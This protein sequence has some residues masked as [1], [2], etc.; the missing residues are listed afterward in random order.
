M[1]FERA[2]AKGLAVR[3]FG[4][5]SPHALTLLRAAWPKAVGE[6][7]GRRTEVVALEGVTLR[8]RVPDAGWR[9]VLHRMQ[10]EIL[11]RLREV[12]GPLAPRRL[13]F[14]EGRIAVADAAPAPPEPVSSDERCPPGLVDEAAAIAD[15]EVRARFVETA[16]R[17]LS[18]AGA[19]AGR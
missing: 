18:R 13:G 7:L 14:V 17:Y 12:A 6:D 5:D 3:L 19:R 8:I 15:P 9:R 1:R 16:G 10:G 11:A 4:K 2:S